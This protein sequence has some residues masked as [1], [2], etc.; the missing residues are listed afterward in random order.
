M[1]K[2]QKINKLLLL[3]CCP[4]L[5]SAI[6]AFNFGAKGLREDIQTHFFVKHH[7]ST[8]TIVHTHTPL[9]LNICTT[10][11]PEYNM[12]T[13]RPTGVHKKI[14]GNANKPVINEVL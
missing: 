8:N 1:L 13:K 10:H 5:N 6:Q 7:N 4:H 2:M 14:Y 3:L 9:L 12:G 11:F